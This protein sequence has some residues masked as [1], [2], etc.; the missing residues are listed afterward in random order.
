MEILQLGTDILK[1]DSSV[2][3]QTSRKHSR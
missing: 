2:H 1:K 3:L